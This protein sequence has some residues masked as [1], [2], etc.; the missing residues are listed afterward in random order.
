MVAVLIIFNIGHV[1]LLSAG[2]CPGKCIVDYG[3]NQNGWCS[4]HLEPCPESPTGEVWVM[5]CGKIKAEYNGEVYPCK[6]NFGG[7]EVE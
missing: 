3:P 7:L 4:V 5:K 2:P 1:G 6:R